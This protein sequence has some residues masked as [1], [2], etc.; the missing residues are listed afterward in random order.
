MRVGWR[1]LRTAKHGTCRLSRATPPAWTVEIYAE[2][3][4]SAVPETT[5]VTIRDL[6]GVARWARQHASV[7][8]QAKINAIIEAYARG[9]EQEFAH[10]PTVWEIDRVYRGSEK[11]F[12]RL[13]LINSETLNELWGFS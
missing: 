8:D 12:Y 9:K 10:Q 1:T 4:G 11:E 6:D 13:A 7:A 2:K 5:T 3:K